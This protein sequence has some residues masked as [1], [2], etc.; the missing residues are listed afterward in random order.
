[1]EKKTTRRVYDS[2]GRKAA[3]EDT[4]LAILGAARRVFL[5]RGYVGATMSLI[6][7]EAGIAAPRHGVYARS[8]QEAGLVPA[9]G[10]RPAISGQ[11]CGW[12]GAGGAARLW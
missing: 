9:A 1:M 2:S 12:R 5:A 8:G 11:S 7:A 6:A 10:R 3:A 4:R